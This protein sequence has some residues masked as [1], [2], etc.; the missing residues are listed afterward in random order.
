MIEEKVVIVTGGAGLLG[1]VFCESILEN[2]GIVIIADIDEQKGK[3]TET[4]LNNKFG[5][6]SSLFIK[7]DITSANSIEKLISVVESNYRRI[8]AVINNAYPKNKNYGRHLFN[9]EYDDFCSNINSHLGGYFLVCKIFAKYFKHQGLGNII[10]IASIYGIIAPKFEIYNN[11]TMTVPIEYAVTKSA[12]IHMTKYLAE[13]LKG[14][15]IRVNSISPGGIQDKQPEQFI[16]SYNLK[17]LNKGLLD[18][19]DIVGTLLFL[20]SDNS[21]YINGQN[22]VVD[23]GFT[24]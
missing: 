20:L 10:N 21:K 18:E 24:L 4:Y 15:K 2:K 19:V 22:L 16:E 14:Y 12:V 8:D 9:V 11:T 1:K 5:N 7:V 3:A 17:S 13:Y 6:H 23:D